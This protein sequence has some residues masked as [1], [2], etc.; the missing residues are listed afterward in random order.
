ML[1]AKILLRGYRFIRNL[2]C[3]AY[4]IE[5]NYPRSRREHILILNVG[6]SSRRHNS[7][8]TRAPDNLIFHLSGR[9]LLEI[10]G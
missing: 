9:S 6:F 2:E 8:D 7:I 4:E 1:K 5:C 3:D 10:R